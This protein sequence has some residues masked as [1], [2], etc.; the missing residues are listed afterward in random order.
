MRSQLGASSSVGRFGGRGVCVFTA[1]CRADATDPCV[2]G[3]VIFIF[4][5]ERLPFPCKSTD[6]F[7]P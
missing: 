6:V 7:A 4:F 5:Y 2:R 3:S 1:G